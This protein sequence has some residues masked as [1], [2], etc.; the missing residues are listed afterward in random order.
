MNK[1]IKFIKDIVNNTFAFGIYI[2]SMHLV[3]LPFMAKY[4]E[5]D[6]NVKLL[7][8]IM[9]ANIVNLSLG[10]ELG[11]LYQVKN[12]EES[13]ENKTDFRILLYKTNIIIFIFMVIILSILKF[14]LVEAFMFGLTS[15]LTNTRFFYLGIFRKEK[16]FKLISATNFLFFIGIILGIF[17]FTRGIT[18]L[19]MSLLLAEILSNIC[20]F[21]K[22][23]HKKKIKIKITKYYNELRKSYLDLSFASLLTNFPTYADKLLILPLLGSTNMSAYYAGTA[24]SKMLFLVINPINGVLL[25]YLSTDEFGD[26]RKVIKRQININFIIIVLTFLLSLPLTYV[27]TL[28]FYKQFLDKVVKILIPLS[29]TATFSVASSLLKVIFLKYANIRYL[30]YIN[31]INIVTFVVFATIGAKYYAL[32]GFAY[33]VALSK[34][35]LWLSFYIIIYRNH[36]K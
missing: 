12:T 25:S 8:F 35:I 14:S 7:S 34:F 9:I 4:L 36:Q 30:K 31:I 19:W 11:I 20:V 1:K 16:R 18:F 33:G 13:D 29:I 32:S 6:D 15:T 3:F 2:I 23:Q 26:K 27:A 22:V 24:L 10:H 28:I 21:A 5:V 17:L